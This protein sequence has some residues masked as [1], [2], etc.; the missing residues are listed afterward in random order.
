MLAARIKELLGDDLAKQVEEKLK[1]QGK[2]GKDVEVVVGNDG[3]FVPADKY[4]TLKSEKAAADKLA[5]DTAGQLKAL[6]D[7]GD[8]EKLKTDL[9]AAQAKLTDLQKEHQ[10]EVTKIR[11]SHQAALKVINDAHD[12]SDVVSALDFEKIMLND[13][14][15][16]V[17]GLDEQLNDLKAKKPHWFKAADEGSGTGGIPPVIGGKPAVSANPWKKETF[18]LTE[19]GRILRDNPELAAKLKSQAGSN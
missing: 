18:N 17:S 2:D 8:P 7:A 19:Q 11:K 10:A 14:G 12:P 13:K 16:I 3:S 6:K 1:G 9:T 5:T 4:E 15:E